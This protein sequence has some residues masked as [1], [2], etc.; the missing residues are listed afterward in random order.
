VLLPIAG[1]AALVLVWQGV[2]QTPSGSI[3]AAALD[4]GRQLIAR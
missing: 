4:G 2:P 1:V 3:E